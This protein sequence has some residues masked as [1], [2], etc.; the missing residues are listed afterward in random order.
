MNLE[1]MLKYARSLVPDE[2]IWRTNIKGDNDYFYMKI[3]KRDTEKG[4]KFGH[5]LC[6]TNIGYARY[7]TWKKF[8]IKLKNGLT[9]AE[10]EDRLKEYINYYNECIQTRK[11]YAEGFKNYVIETGGH[12]GN[13]V[14]MD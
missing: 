11:S 10:I 12:K 8:N 4:I 13:P 9:K 3:I 5:V 6:S 2:S 14:W 1:S 7:G